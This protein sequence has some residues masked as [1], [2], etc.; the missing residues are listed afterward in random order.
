MFRFGVLESALRAARAAGVETTDE[1]MAVERTGLR[2]KLLA[3]SA[4]NIKVTVAEDMELAEYYL[5]RPRGRP[6]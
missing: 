1:A 5:S 4:D 2:P 3:G 6:A